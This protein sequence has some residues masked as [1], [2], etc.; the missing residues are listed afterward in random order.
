ML[1]NETAKRR[2]EGKLEVKIKVNGLSWLTQQ[3]N[4]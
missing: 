3:R 4:Q 1:K 2:D